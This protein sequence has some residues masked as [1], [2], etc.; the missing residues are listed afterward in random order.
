MNTQDK[1]ELVKLVGE[2]VEENILPVVALKDDT[3]R[4]EEILNRI[5]RTLNNA[6]NR[7]DERLQG[8][9]ERIQALETQ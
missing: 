5:E 4:M 6:V 1:K 8:H 7:Y 3:D 9:E 2:V